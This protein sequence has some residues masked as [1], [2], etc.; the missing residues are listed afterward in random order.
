[1][2]NPVHFLQNNHQIDQDMD[3]GQLFC[4][5]YPATV[6]NDDKML[7]TLG[8]YQHINETFSQPNRKL[9]LKFRPETPGCKATCAERTKTSSL[10]LKVS[11]F[12]MYFFKRKTSKK[13][14]KFLAKK[15]K[16]V[17]S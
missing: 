10:L 12:R 8:G 4:V 17:K 16:K 1:M 5:E 3:S 13:F 9:E 14:G 7:E 15:L 6:K 2:K 11:N